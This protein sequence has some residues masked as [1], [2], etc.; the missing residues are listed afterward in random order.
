M[1][2]LSPKIVPV[3]YRYSHFGVNRQN[4]VNAC[5]IIQAV[6]L[7]DPADFPDHPLHIVLPDGKLVGSGIQKK[8]S[9][10][11]TDSRTIRRPCSLKIFFQ[12]EPSYSCSALKALFNHYTTIL[13]VAQ[14]HNLLFDKSVLQ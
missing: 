11:Q 7:Q 14:P 13:P 9:G 4:L 10:N 6:V 5:E 2:A 3:S 1:G 12:L 8:G